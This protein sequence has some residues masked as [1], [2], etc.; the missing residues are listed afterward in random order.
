MHG[1]NAVQQ[2]GCLHLIQMRRVCG[3]SFL[4]DLDADD[5]DDD[6]GA[7]DGQFEEDDAY[8]KK[9]RKKAMQLLRGDTAE[10]EEDSDEW[11]DDGEE[12]IGT[13]LDDIDPYVSFADVLGGLQTAM[14]GRYQAL[15]AGAD[16][17]V[18]AALQRMSE[19]AAQ[20]KQ[21]KE[22]EAAGQ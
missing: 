17:S 3:C 12:T 2:L 9:L 16:A 14:P 6:D 5:G 15:V 22:A 21:K 20:V 4:Q 10:D 18:I 11:T 19:Y 1:L 13:P 7:D 8:M